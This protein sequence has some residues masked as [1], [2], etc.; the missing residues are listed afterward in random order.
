MPSEKTEAAS[1]KKTRLELDYELLIQFLPPTVPTPAY[2]DSFEQPDP[3]P[4]VQTMTTY[5]IAAEQL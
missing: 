4:H 5:G 1:K 2:R 3:Y